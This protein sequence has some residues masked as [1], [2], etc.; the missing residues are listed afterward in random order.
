MY[1][2]VVKLV[3]M[4]KRKC[5]TRW[6]SLCYEIR[7]YGPLLSVAQRNTVA[8]QGKETSQAKLG[9]KALLLSFLWQFTVRCR[10]PDVI[11]LLQV[12]RRV[13]SCLSQHL[14][15]KH[16]LYFTFHQQNL[17]VA[18]PPLFLPPSTPNVKIMHAES[19]PDKTCQ[20]I[21]AVVWI[22]N[23]IP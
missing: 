21:F 20:V 6:S 23:L 7:R 15:K 16:T 4:A 18:G 19:I 12:R 3:L 9:R 22:F 2:S 1:L 11:V 8:C 5:L 17:F 10:Q 13:T 14:W